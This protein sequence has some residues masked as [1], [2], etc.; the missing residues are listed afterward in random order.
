MLIASTDPLV[1]CTGLY[2][3]YA[4]CTES[5]RQPSSTWRSQPTYLTK[6]MSLSAWA[7]KLDMSVASHSMMKG[8]SWFFGLHLF[9]PAKVPAISLFEAT[10]AEGA[11]AATRIAPAA[12]TKQGVARRRRPET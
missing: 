2:D 7:W 10:F 12:R 5:S 4:P 9:W 3:P 8:R 11:H 1:H 6:T